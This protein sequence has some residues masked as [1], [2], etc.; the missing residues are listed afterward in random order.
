MIMDKW[1]DKER[2]PFDGFAKRDPK[3]HE[4][5]FDPIT[6]ICAVC[7]KTREDLRKEWR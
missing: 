5:N 2:I 7:L 1:D 4:H 3:D 6:G